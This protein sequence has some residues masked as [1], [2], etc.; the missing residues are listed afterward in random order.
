M[1]G[2]GFLATLFGAGLAIVIAAI[3]ALITSGRAVPFPARSRS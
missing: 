1:T 2:L 3:A